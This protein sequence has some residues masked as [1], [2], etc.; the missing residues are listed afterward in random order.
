MKTPEVC[1]ELRLRLHGYAISDQADTGLTLVW[2]RFVMN[3]N[4]D[5]DLPSTTRERRSGSL[6]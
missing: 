6:S 3:L 5:T 1:V 2:V 4:G